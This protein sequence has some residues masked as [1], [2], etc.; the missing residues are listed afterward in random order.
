M[1]GTQMFLIGLL[2]VLLALFA[3]GRWRYD[4]VAFGALV[5]A[6]LAGA[7]PADEMF[8]GLGH[9]ATVTVALVLIISRAL[10]A[11]GA[12]DLIARSLL[13]PLERPSH[14][15]GL[16]ATVGG[17][18][19]TMMNNV[20]ALAL[21]M[22]AALQ[23]AARAGHAP[24]LVLMPLSFGT[25]L[26]GLATLIGTPPNIIVATFRGHAVG[27]PF[28]M[29]DFTP[30]GG[31]IAVAGIVF[32]SL[33]GWRLIPADRRARPSAG[34][35]EDLENYVGEATVPAESK[36]IGRSLEE[37]DDTAAQHDAVILRVLRNDRRIDLAGR[38]Q[39]IQESDMLVIEAGS[40]DMDAV[41]KALDLRPPEDRERSRENLIGTS[42]TSLM[43]AVVL[44]RSRLEG[45]TRES[46]R[47]RRRYG[48]SLLAVS[49]RGHFFR[50]RMRSFRFQAGDILLFEGESERLA[51]IVP[52]LGCLPLASRTSA[53]SS[54]RPAILS[55]L[56]FAAAIIIATAGLTGLPVTLAA[57]AT[58]MVL[59]RILP[60]RD[61]Y[62]SVDWPVILLLGA[63]IPIGGALQSSGVTD[64]VADGLV[65]L[66]GTWPAAA[67]L[68]III[69][70]TMTLSDIINNAATAVVMAP[71]SMAIAEQ[72]G[73]SSDPFLMAVAIGASCAF[74]TPIG[75]Q[76]NTLILGPGGYRFADYWRM[77]LPLEVLIVLV[78]IPMILLV[79]PL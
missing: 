55:M 66:T 6:T 57:A 14:Q 15:V 44:Q 34:E 10:R 36:A 47:L 24:A 67:I 52:A 78:A 23:S 22:P 11:S 68:A 35:F 5:L 30:V 38:S 72:L 20:G 73:V 25:I 76:N 43:Q 61:L 54:R 21:M 29:F 39:E 71:I 31:T 64:L 62:E 26:G 63:M 17:A 53:P 77:G 27:Q 70:V 1:T 50:G 7:V 51:A 74:L 48:I 56:L 32:V 18:L 79:W 16:F 45:Q 60:L 28:T 19:S 4:V 33:V 46:M 3:W 65:T 49:R 8:S 75:H 58:G 69:V 13:P 40:D 59:L 12:V 37:L 2:V 9:P 41:F 42:E